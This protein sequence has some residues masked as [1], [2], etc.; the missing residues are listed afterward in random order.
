MKTITC[1]ICGLQIPI[2]ISNNAWPITQGECCPN[3]NRDLVIPARILEQRTHEIYQ[4]YMEQYGSILPTQKETIKSFLTQNK[5]IL[6]QK[7]IQYI[8]DLIQD[9]IGSQQLYDPEYKQT[10]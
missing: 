4:A 1:S 5:D 2:E 7:P 3:C 9:Y 10:W 6:K 8:I